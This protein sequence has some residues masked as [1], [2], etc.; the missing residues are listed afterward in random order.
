MMMVAMVVVVLSGWGCRIV[1]YLKMGHHARCM[2]LQNMTVVHP[3]ARAVIGHPGY[4]YR[5]SGRQVYGIFP[6]PE[7]RWF[8]AHFQY[9]EEKSVQVKRVI[10]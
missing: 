3:P 1:Y 2:V 10:H 9:L 7:D 4:F 5:A 6:G 8:A